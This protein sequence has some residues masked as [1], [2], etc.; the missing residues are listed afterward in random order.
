MNLTVSFSLGGCMCWVLF[1]G[2]GEFCSSFIASLCHFAKI[3]VQ[4]SRLW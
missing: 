1:S 4:P 3:L 2:F